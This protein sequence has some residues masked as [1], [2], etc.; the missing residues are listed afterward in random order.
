MTASLLVDIHA[1]GQLPIKFTIRE[2]SG[3]ESKI[4]YQNQSLMQI[5][6]SQTKEPPEVPSTC[7][8][9]LVEITGNP[10]LYIFQGKN[11]LLWQFG[12]EHKVWSTLVFFSRSGIIFNEQFCKSWKLAQEKPQGHMKGSKRVD[13]IPHPWR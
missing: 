2:K 9:L 10:C 6:P 4:S 12:V 8:S 11:A 1:T 5:F 13:L 7:F 3:E